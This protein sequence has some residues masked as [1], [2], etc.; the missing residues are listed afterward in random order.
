MKIKLA[1]IDDDES[2]VKRLI[3]NFQINYAG[4][5][6]PYFFSSFLSFIKFYEDNI[7]QVLLVSEK[8]VNDKAQIPKDVAFAWLVS[9]NVIKELEGCPAVGKYQKAELLYKSVLGLYADRESSLVLRGGGK[10]KYIIFTSAQGGAGTSTIAAAYALNR[11][12]AGRNPFYLNLDRLGSPALFFQGDGNLGF[13]EALYAIKARK[14]NLALKL[15]SIAKRDK[16]GISFFDVCKNARDMMEINLEDIDLLFSALNSMESFDDVIIDLPLDFSPVCNVILEQY[17]DRI[18]FINDGSS[19]GNLKFKSAMEV[20]QI[21]QKKGKLLMKTR[22]LYNKADHAEKTEPGNF[23]V[24]ALGKINHMG[25]L[26]Q[27][28]TFERLSEHPVM[29]KIG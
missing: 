20:L 7:V 8:F 15:E 24:E 28:Q 14:G 19:T 27:E 12:K 2:Y 5:I 18:I 26:S 21:H 29:G 6:E 16:R 23:G 13:S 9:D 22:I 1:I 4:K 25:M 11:A 3:N 17:A 10:R